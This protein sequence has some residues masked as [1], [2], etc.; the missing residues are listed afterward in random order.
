MAPTR[1]PFPH[2]RPMLRSRLTVLALS[3]VLFA[4]C[5]SSGGGAAPD[6]SAEPA[7]RLVVLIDTRAGH[8]ALVQFV[9]AGAALE[10][11]RGGLTEDLLRGSALVVFDDP[12]GAPAALPLAA[13]PAD[14]Y[15]A[16]HLVLVP[17]SGQALEA[18][19][20]T[21][22]VRGPVDL[23][24]PIPDGLEHGANAPSWLVV[25]HDEPS[26]AVA[27]GELSW[28]PALSARLGGEPLVVDGLEAPVAGGD[29]L[30]VTL[31]AAADAS[32]HLR[33]RP[34]CAFTDEVGTPYAGLGPFLD[35]LT[36]AD[37]VCVDADV[38]RDGCADV[39]RIW[40]GPRDGNVRLIGRVV[41][42]DPTLPGFTLDVQATNGPG[43]PSVLAVPERVRVHTADACFAR[44]NGESLTFADLAPGRL[45]KVY[46]RSFTT[47]PGAPRCYTA[48]RVEL[49]GQGAPAGRMWQGRVTAVDLVARTIGIE[50]RNGPAFVVA[51]Q[52][53]PAIRAHVAPGTPIERRGVPGAGAVA[54]DLADVQPGVDRIWVRG[55]ATNPPTIEASRVRVRAQ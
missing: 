4:A 31:R 14:T 27:A 19:G 50:P 3:S 48:Y 43:A 44:P 6:A 55:T 16:L 40:R 39:R 13:A 29:G 17:G 36:V 2:P 25:G 11:A 33:W 52:P 10:R 32:L 49:P 9:V 41:D 28:S 46:W 38:W 53:F 18:N 42:V 8:D 26:L 22:V 37:R 30:A 24:I 35:A 23:R 15:A 20:S 51:G 34:D 12:A 47:A 45:A 5:G 21:R 7:G 54:I 1:T